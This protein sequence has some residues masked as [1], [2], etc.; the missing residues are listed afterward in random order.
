MLAAQ[1]LHTLAELPLLL[2]PLHRDAILRKRHGRTIAHATGAGKGICKPQ[3]NGVSSLP[4]AAD[5]P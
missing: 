5:P 2:Q 4:E 3:G 1:A